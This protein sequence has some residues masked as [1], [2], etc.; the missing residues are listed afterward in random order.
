MDADDQN[1]EVGIMGAGS[2]K[3]PASRSAFPRAR[4]PCPAPCARPSWMPRDRRPPWPSASSRSRYR[5][6]ARCSSGSGRSGSGTAAVP[7]GRV[8]RFDQIVE[9]HTDM[10]QNRA[11]GKLVVTT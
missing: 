4:R 6:P 7:I 10:E 11:S 9:A 2:G 8:Y 1:V 3:P 5:P